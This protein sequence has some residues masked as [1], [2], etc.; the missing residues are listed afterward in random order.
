MY[1]SIVT[2]GVTVFKLTCVTSTVGETSGSSIKLTRTPAV[3]TETKLPLKP[4]RAQTLI[5][6][7]FDLS[8]VDVNIQTRLDIAVMGDSE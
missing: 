2:P 8:D 5:T 3:S 6:R 1:D 7:R 4:S